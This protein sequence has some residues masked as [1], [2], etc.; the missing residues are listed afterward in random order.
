MDGPRQDP[1]P[2]LELVVLGATGSIGRQ[3]LDVVTRHPDRLR[4]CAVSCHARLAE[5]EELLAGL[6]AFQ[7]GLQ[8]LVAITDPAAHAAAAGQGTFGARLLPA[9]PDALPDLIR[10]AERAQV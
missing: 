5:L 7:E 8:P 4:V 9:G 2:P 1:A 6:A 10:A 3:T